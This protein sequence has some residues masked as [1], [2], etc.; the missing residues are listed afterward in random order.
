[1]IGA[2]AGDVIGSHFE[3]YPTKR[4]DFPRFAERTC[5]TDDTVLTVA[6]ADAILRGQPYAQALRDFGRRYPDRGYGNNFYCWMLNEAMGPYGSWGNGSAMRVSPVGH[7][8]DS[9]ERV[10]AQARESAVPTHDHEEGVKGAQSVALAIFLA[11][12]GAEK[13]R[14]RD[15]VSARFGYDL[16]RTLEQI[17][18]RYCFEISCQTSVPESIIAFVESESVEDAIRK[19][20]SLG[21]DSDT[22]G[23]I[24]GSIAEAYYGEPPADLVAGVRGFLP[25]EFL[26]IIDEFEAAF[27]SRRRDMRRQPWPSKA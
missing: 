8:F 5:F 1:V 26:R 25:A 16:D 7:A 15:E 4:T 14:I 20:I 19:A 12:G 24:A 11:R 6:V 27:P 13:E 21:G 23:C 10:L 2:I 18:P 9:V 3:S 17:R 22:M